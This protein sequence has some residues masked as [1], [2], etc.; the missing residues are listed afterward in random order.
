[1]GDY[2]FLL[3]VIAIDITLFFKLKLLCVTYIDLYDSMDL[4]ITMFLR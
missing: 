4:V 1:M 2:Y 3:G